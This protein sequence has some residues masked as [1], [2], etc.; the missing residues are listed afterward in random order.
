VKQLLDFTRARMAGGIPL[1]PGDTALEAVARRIITELEQ[2]HPGRSIALE[3]R[4][5]C[6]GHWDE[7]RLGQVL[8]NLVANALQ[9]SPEGTPV[10]VRLEA[11]GPQQRLE[12]HNVGAP[13]P[14]ALRP[15]LFEPFHPS[16][17][18]GAPRQARS[19]LGLGLYIVAQ[20]VQAHG[21]GVEVRSTR[22]EGTCFTVTLPR[23]SPPQ[24]EGAEEPARQAG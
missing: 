21:G 24:E 1:R 15:H 13:I 7:E 4:G 14:E 20:I 8:S 5:E 23:V 2:V 6:R 18:E 19:G 9:N 10:Q 11:V 3:V 22:E 16:Q 12:V 17:E